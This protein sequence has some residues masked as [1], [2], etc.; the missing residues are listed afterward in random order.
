MDLRY[1]KAFV[2]AA[3][4]K[5]FSKAALELSISQSA[6]GR[7]IKL[8]EED[9]K[10]K[11]FLRSHKEVQLTEKGFELL[12]IYEK[13]EEEYQLIF[14]ADRKYT[15]RIGLLSGVLQ[16]WFY[17]I[18]EQ[19]YEKFQHQIEIRVGSFAEI[20]SDLIHGKLDLCLSHDNM[21]TN[22]FTSVL[23]L[24]ENFF[25]IS[26]REISLNKLHEYT[27]II[28]GPSD[29]IFQLTKKRPQKTLLINSVEAM[30]IMV[31]KGVGI[32]M[33]PEHTFTKED[34]FHSSIKKESGQTALYLVMKNEE[35]IPLRI[36]E[37]VNL[38]KK[39]F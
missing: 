35:K 13:F 19:Y 27:W 18:I 10:E 36:K 29:P 14:S 4:T 15:L 38:I 5:K 33:L 3:R 26:S 22:S 8:L 20:K 32:A 37:L 6:L 31:K 39:S 25:I 1:L 21:Q 23:L 9:L 7:Q 17:D 16:T 24:K 30:K 11:L 28:H 34:F 12:T 2:V